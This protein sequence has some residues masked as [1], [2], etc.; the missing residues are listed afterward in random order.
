MNIEIM[1]VVL[2]E[3]AQYTFDGTG[4]LIDFTPDKLQPDGKGLIG[5][6][7][8]WHRFLV[9]SGGA[10]KERHCDDFAGPALF[11]EYAVATKSWAGF[12]FE[13][14]RDVPFKYAVRIR[15]F[16]TGLPAEI[17]AVSGGAAFGKL[18]LTKARRPVEKDAK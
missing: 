8:R 18:K 13:Q 6:T 5:T 12:Y 14:L 15:D 17:V 10:F 2:G 3:S 11:L 9:L 7:G 16:D 1:D 4:P